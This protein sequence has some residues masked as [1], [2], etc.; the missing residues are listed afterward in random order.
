MDTDMK[1]EGWLK[2]RQFDSKRRFVDKSRPFIESHRG[3]NKEEPENTISAFRRAIEI[4][5]DSIELDVWLTKDDVPVVIHGMDNGEINE[6]TKGSGSV[7]ELTIRELS[8]ITV[9]GKDEGVPSLL[10]V[11]QLCKDKIFINIEIKD[12]NHKKCLDQVL[13]CIKENRMDEQVAIS[14]FQHEYWHEMIKL[15]ESIEF[16]FLYDTTE[17]Q[18]CEFCFDQE[19]KN[20]TINLW[21]KEVTPELVEKAHKNDFAVHCWFCLED[22]ETD[23]IFR[24][25]F[26]CGVDIVCTNSPLLAMKIR[27][28]IY[29]K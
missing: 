2:R 22:P 18:I 6:T 13:C 8:S 12:K 7:N 14:S 17:G 9:K 23:E 11:F 21:Y 27:D 15:K 19:R 26:N 3:V 29:G 20:N 25:L 10:E 28:E 4:G 24:Y 16:G 1:T 5:C